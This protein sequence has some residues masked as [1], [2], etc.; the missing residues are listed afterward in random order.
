MLKLY[1]SAYFSMFKALG[2]IPPHLQHCK[3][4]N[5]K[6]LINPFAQNPK[7]KDGGKF[8]VKKSHF[9]E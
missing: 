4:N 1:G 3:T 8:K 7:E 9:L 5:N 6:T 2:L